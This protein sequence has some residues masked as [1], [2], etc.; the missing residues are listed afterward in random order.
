MMYKG[1]KY[2]STAFSPP[3]CTVHIVT[4]CHLVVGTNIRGDKS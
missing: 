3:F 1:N 4:P 2:E